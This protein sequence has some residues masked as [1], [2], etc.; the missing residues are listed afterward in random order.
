MRLRAEY[1]VGR[2]LKFLGNLDMM[3]LMSRAM[4]RAGIPFALSEGFNPHIKLSMGTV[5]PVGVWGEN[6]YF[7]LEL[8]QDMEPHEFMARMNRVLPHGM[9]IRQCVKM[10]DKE[11]ALM[12][13][14]NA[15]SYTFILKNIDH[16]YSDLPDKIMI[17]NQ[18]LVKSRGKQKGI[19]KDL[20]PGI[21][22]I[23]VN[24]QQE[25]VMIS[26]WVNV[27]E[28]VNVRYDELLDLLKDQGIE[29]EEVADIYR[30][31]NF[32]RAGNLFYSP[33]EKVS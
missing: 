1:R 4:R 8:K 29:H 30:S 11:P 17:Q 14:I 31:G 28:P 18:L 21:F 10:D 3:N 26:I 19:D 25:S 33:F 15:A 5:L 22:K 23:A 20:R 16:D 12:R 32:I 6:E 9:E 7:D 24:Y 27:G 13:I 2:D